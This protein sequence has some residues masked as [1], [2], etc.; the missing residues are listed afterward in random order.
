VAPAGWTDKITNGAPPSDGYS[1]RWV[2][3]SGSELAPGSSL[4]FQFVSADPPST[5]AG[6]STI[7]PGT[8]IGTS[9]LYQMGPF[10]GDTATIVVASVPEPSTLTLGVC[11]SLLSMVFLRLRRQRRS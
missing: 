3:N 8:P 4:M 5:L 6:M 11:G 10:A 9:T 7:H 1:I 2:A